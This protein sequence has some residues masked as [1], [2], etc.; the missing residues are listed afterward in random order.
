MKPIKLSVQGLNSFKDLQTIEFDKLTQYGL[1]GVFGPTGSGKS[2]ILDGMTLALYGKT[3][4]DSSN[5]IHV[6][7]DKMQVVFEFAVNEKVYR[8]VRSYRRN[9]QGSINASKPTRIEDITDQA[10]ILEEQTTSVDKKCLEII[11]LEFKDFIRTVVLPQGKF[12]EFINLKGKDRREMLERLFSLSRYGDDLSRKLASTIRGEKDA[13]LALEGQMKGYEHVSNEALDKLKDDLSETMKLVKELKLK[14]DHKKESY[15]RSLKLFDLGEQIKTLKNQ[16]LKLN[17]DEIR[18]EEL[19]EEIVLGQKILEV[20]PYYDRW[21]ESGKEEKQVELDLQE[22]VKDIK[23]LMINVEALEK[24]FESIKLDYEA[25]MKTYEVKKHQY[26]EGIKIEEEVRTYKSQINDLNK[27]LETLESNIDQSQNDLKLV[28]DNLRSRQVKIEDLNQASKEY[29]VPLSLQ[30]QVDKGAE[31][32]S[33]ISQVKTS[34][35]KY[36]LD[37]DQKIIDDLTKE[38]KTSLDEIETLDTQMKS[39]SVVS[40]EDY[41]DKHQKLVKTLDEALDTKSKSSQLIIEIEDLSKEIDDLKPSYDDYMKRKDQAFIHKLQSQLEDGKAC[42]VC[43]SQDHH[44]QL[45]FETFEVDTTL[46]EHMSQLLFN[47]T[48]KEEALKGLKAIDQSY[49]DGLNQDKETLDTDYKHW[50][51]SDQKLTELKQLVSRHE[52]HFKH[53]S[54]THKKNKD[55][56]KGLN[57]KLNILVE[58]LKALEVDEVIDNYTSYKLSIYDKLLKHQETKTIIDGLNLECQKLNKQVLD[59]NEAIGSYNLNS[60][61]KKQEVLK[62]IELMTSKESKLKDMFGGADDLKEKLA[63]LNHHYDQLTF[64]FNQNK[65]KLQDDTEKMKSLVD[66]RLRLE[67]VLETNTKRHQTNKLKLD[68]IL[69]KND[70]K[71]DQMNN[72]IWTRELLKSKSEQVEK[73]KEEKTR[74]ETTLKTLTEQ[75]GDLVISRD[76]VDHL[77]SE[78][79]LIE[80]E[81]KA[82]YD[83]SVGLDKDVKA[84]MADMLKL[85]DLLDQ[86]QSI[87]YK[88][89][90][91]KELESLFKGKKFVEFVASY[92]LRYISIEASKR[93]YDITSGK[94]GLEV[95]DHGM[96]LVRDYSHGGQT[97]D[98]STLSGGES[99]LVSLCLA[100]SLSSQIQLK[101]TAPLE[102]FFLDEGFGTLDERFLELVMSSLEKIHHKNLSIG[103][104]SHVDSIKS[105]VPIKLMV[106]PSISGERGSRVKIEKT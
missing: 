24:K 105:R 59:L 93:L 81:Y 102:L 8:V 45:T 89:S 37:H 10:I 51:A 39:F 41:M 67:A 80:D 56:Y 27:N 12:S 58:E 13:S 17:Q 49:I 26:N 34:L 106:S 15:D 70:L 87:D 90:L 48:N 78:L 20:T 64:S 86:R 18:I 88:L 2:T 69:E 16:A 73:Y 65:N 25:F 22:I 32:E 11:G 14:L 84:M 5:F 104:I 55:E 28:E 97:R 44:Y 35:D 82:S 100:L 47:L 42:P 9:K 101:G 60:K 3:S 50:K 1:F 96:F 38:I 43:G 98:M 40:T 54:E 6:E 4:R 94:Y 61:L 77:K 7:S 91:L 63:G 95:D 36:K 29:D 103:L 74:I 23:P 46:E 85:K 52:E 57:D 92:Q 19:K 31:I 79:Q 33:Q 66:N 83:K 71:L 21:I 76:Q 62:L 75:V 72:H 68:Q 53:V 30:K 99:F